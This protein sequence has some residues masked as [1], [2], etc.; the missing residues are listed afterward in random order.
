MIRVGLD[1]PFAAK[2]EAKAAGARWDGK[3]WYAPGFDVAYARLAR[4]L[5][6]ES[7]VALLCPAGGETAIAVA[8]GAVD[9]G[10]GGA[11]VPTFLGALIE[12]RVVLQ[13]LCYWLPERHPDRRV[14]ASVEAAAL[15]LAEHGCRLPA[16]LFLPAEKA[17]MEHLVAQ[18]E[19][20]LADG[21]ASACYV[22][23]S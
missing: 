19:W 1:V 12:G 13:R 16:A 18:G 7:R 17:V 14:F 11:F 23:I 3:S 2:D 9:D 15:H 5:R 20:R 6:P 22:K 8:R 21:E 4:W 10:A